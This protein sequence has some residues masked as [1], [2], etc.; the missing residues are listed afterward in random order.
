MSLHLGRMKGKV[1]SCKP[2]DAWQ[3]KAARKGRLGR[4]TFCT[5]GKDTAKAIAVPMMGR[6]ELSCVNSVL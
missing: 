4:L 5:P 3:L 2:W 6:V 1:R